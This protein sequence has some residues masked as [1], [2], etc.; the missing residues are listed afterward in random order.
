MLLQRSHQL[1]KNIGGIKVN[2]IVRSRFCGCKK[3]KGT[4]QR[5]GSAQAT[6]FPNHRNQKFKALMMPNANRLKTS[7]LQAERLLAAKAI[8]FSDWISI[9][10]G[11]WAEAS[12]C[13]A[14][15]RRELCRCGSAMVPVS[16][17]FSSNRQHV[18]LQ[19]VRW[20]HDASS[21]LPVKKHCW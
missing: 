3:K 11:C 17:F 4:K 2:S 18:N 19:H 15:T 5:Q 6:P 7:C 13:A 20:Q 9:C 10:L 21:V 12:T 1:H 8:A 16:A 14:I